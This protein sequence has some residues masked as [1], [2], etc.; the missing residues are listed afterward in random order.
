MRNVNLLHCRHTGWSFGSLPGCPRTDS[1]RRSLVRLG[2]RTG[3][4][5][6]V[7]IHRRRTC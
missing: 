1:A 6:I 2:R 3:F 5:R 4:R 7:D